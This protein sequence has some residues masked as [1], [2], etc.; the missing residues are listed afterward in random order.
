MTEAT[1]N[2][3]HIER[4]EKVR[5][6]V[7]SK[8]QAEKDTNS[9]K[10]GVVQQSTGVAQQSHPDPNPNQA[11]GLKEKTLEPTKMDGKLPSDPRTAEYAQ[12][13][14]DGHPYDPDC[15]VCNRAYMRN[16]PAM[17]SKGST[18]KG[19][20]FLRLL[21]GANTDVLK[22]N[23]K[24]VDGNIGTS[25]IILPGTAFGE[26]ENLTN[27]RAFTKEQKW[28]KMAH[29]IQSQTDPGGKAGY[30]IER[31]HSDQGKENEGEHREAMDEGN[32]VNTK[33]HRDYHTAGSSIEGYFNRLQVK[34][35]A[36]GVGGLGDNEHLLKQ[37]MGGR[38]KHSC[39][40]LKFKPTTK[41]QKEQDISPIQE[42]YHM[43]C[44]GDKP[45]LT[46]GDLVIGFIAKDERPSKLGPRGFRSIYQTDDLDI[47]GNIIVW[48]FTTSEDG[49]HWEVL[50]SKS[51]NQY[52]ACPGVAILATPPGKPGPVPMDF[53]QPQEGELTY[54]QAKELFA[55]PDPDPGALSEEEDE[56]EYA[57]VEKIVQHEIGDDGQIQY[58]VRWKGYDHTWDSWRT[59]K[60]LGCPE[61]L[62]EY[63][64]KVMRGEPETD[65]GAIMATL[66]TMQL[67]LEMVMANLEAEMTKAQHQLE[68]LTQVCMVYERGAPTVQD[69]SQYQTA[70]FVGEGMM[71][72]PE[73]SMGA[74]V[75]PEE[76]IKTDEGTKA[77]NKELGE[78]TTRRFDTT[79][80]IPEHLKK[81]AMEARLVCNHKRDLSAKA[82]L[83][84]KDL[85][86]KRQVDARKTYAAVPGQYGIRLLVAATNKRGH[87][88]ST[89]DL[90]TAYL[91]SEEWD[92]GSYML[93]KYRDPFTGEWVYVWLKGE[94][95]GLQTAG[96]SWKKSLVTRMVMRGGFI[97]VKNQENM[98]YHPE[99]DILCAV[100]VDDPLKDAPDEESHR[101]FH[102]FMDEEF[103]TNGENRLTPDNMID[104]LSM[105]MTTTDEDVVS[106][107]NKAKINT[108][109]K[110]AGYEGI[111]PSKTAP[112]L[113]SKLK[114]AYQMLDPL[115]SQEAEEMD[116]HKGRFN[117][118]AE[119]TH[120]SLRTASSIYSGMPP[121]KG[122][123]MIMES[124]YAWMEAHKE[125]GISADPANQEGFMVYVDSD[126]GGMHSINGELRSRTGIIIKYNGMPVYWKSNL[127]KT[128]CTEFHPEEGAKF[129]IATSSA[130]AEVQ[131]GAEATGVM[132]HLKYITE[133]LG[134][135]VSS[136]QII[137]TDATAAM[138]FFR[139]TGAGGKMKHIDIRLG[140]V[141]QI[142]DRSLV[143]WEKIP[144]PNNPAD[145]MTKLLEGS[146]FDRHHNSPMRA[147][148]LN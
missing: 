56:E 75:R 107:S 25:G 4:L 21:E 77:V 26:V 53:R 5:A 143:E 113:K 100:F 32:I 62:N 122:S 46:L 17:R 52:K 23:D 6:I 65:H 98:Y 68:E 105:E 31:M 96:S 111:K 50:P 127:Q 1:A 41:D 141:Q 64:D 116:Q 145:A 15:E 114:Q 60:G 69:T 11:M 16:K 40:L 59:K 30:K 36:I 121:I 126:W 82:R 54:E 87:I 83:V 13:C 110:E 48:P 119:T 89:T 138:G 20:T 93:I 67:D 130:A 10:T 129:D 136:P 22:F 81:T 45:K 43:L 85:K 57:E 94:V 61:L 33:G 91:Q 102:D 95:Y 147:I 128:Q 37:T 28:Q 34:A 70:F 78:M 55:D 123:L 12:H 112:I 101:W 44:Q 63:V 139:N 3:E 106:L 133:E 146:D 103:D 24:D 108:M 118:I 90:V 142:R 79:K 88:K 19:N 124:L 74:E 66:D 125:E 109:V 137:Y 134:M 14:L 86:R 71:D 73:P 72:E 84:I 97:E 49:L 29:R 148:T 104:F 9:P 58:Q 135:E 131:A 144:G 2:Q 99:K 35:A 76:F 117:W 120:P 39:L 140:W 132:L 27:M 18:K 7:T 38:I 47:P 92:K 80:P 115:D 51:I 8:R 42:Q